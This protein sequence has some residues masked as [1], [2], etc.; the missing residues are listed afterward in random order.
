MLEWL[1]RLK[2]KTIR[3]ISIMLIFTFCTSLLV[4]N[5]TKAMAA[6]STFTESTTA[7]TSLPVTVTINTS[8]INDYYYD[9]NVRY[10]LDGGSTWTSYT[11]PVGIY[12]NCTIKAQYED[13]YSKKS[14][15]WIDLGSFAVS[16]I[17]DPNNGDWHLMSL[18]LKNTSEA[19][20]MVR[21]GDIDNFTYGW[22][23]DFNPFSGNSTNVHGYPW[24][25]PSDSTQATDRIMVNSGYVYGSGQATD[26]YT[27]STSR[28]TNSVRDIKLS[29]DLSGLTVN[30][31]I[32]QMFVD[33]FQAGP[34][35]DNVS[36]HQFHGKYVVKI[37]NLE[38]PELETVINSLNQSGPRGRMISF[39]I[40]DADI[41]LVKSGS[42]SINIDDKVS[43]EGDGYA[44]DFVKLLIN[45]NSLSQTC[46][47][48][49]TIKD[50]TTGKPIQGATISA[51]DVVKAVSA[52]DGTYT[53]NKVPAGTVVATATANGYIT[54]S[55]TIV[56]AVA[57][58]TYTLDFNMQSTTQLAKP[59]ITETPIVTT[60]QNVNVSI[61]YPGSNIAKKLYY[62]SAVQKDPNNPNQGYTIPVVAD[63]Q[64]KTYNGTISIGNEATASTQYF[65]IVQAKTISSLD[66]TTPQVVNCDSNITTYTINNIDKSI[67]NAPILTANTTTPTS[68]SV[69]VTATFPA[70]DIQSNSLK[71]GT[72]MISVDGGLHFTACT[73]NS[74]NQAIVTLDNNATVQA[75]Y[76]NNAGTDSLI[77][78][79]NI[80]NID[81]SV[82]A[83]PII[84]STPNTLADGTT[85]QSISINYPGSPATQ[86]VSF[87]GVTWKNWS[88]IAGQ[89]GLYVMTYNSIIYAKSINAVGTPSTVA[90]LNVNTIVPG[91]PIITEDVTTPTNKDVN[92][93]IQYPAS[94]VQ[95]QYS[96]DGINWVDYNGSILISQNTTVQAKCMDK[97]GTQ[98]AI[99]SLSI[100]NIDKSTPLAPTLSEDVTT[101]TNKDVNVTAQ[102]PTVGVK[103][104]SQMISTDGGKTFAAYTV[105]S[106]NKV[107][108]PV[109]SNGVIE[110]KYT[111]F[112]GTDSIIA[113]L[114]ITNIDKSTP[115]AP[116]L[117]QDITIETSHDV[118]VTIQ[119]PST[120][121]K[122]GSQLVS[123][124]GGQ[125]FQSYNV[126]SN[127][128]VNITL[129]SNA[130]V[131]A[132]YTNL[133]GTESTVGILVVSNIDKS[134]PGTPVITS[135]G[136][137]LADGTTAVKTSVNYPGNPVVQKVSF[138]N[139]ATW[140]D[141]SDVINNDD[142][143]TM[144]YND[145]VL[146]YSI[147][148]LGTNSATAT[149]KISTIKPGTPIMAEDITAPTNENVNVTIQYPASA[150][151]KQ[152]S[153]DGSNWSVYNGPI[154]VLSNLTVEARCIDKAGTV[155]DVASLNITNIDKSVP[156]APILTA[157]ITAPTSKDVT[158]T[159]QFPTTGVKADS[160]LISVNGGQ[161]Y[162]EC[163]V[164]SNGVA[165]ITVGSNCTVEAKYSNL[166]GTESTTAVLN[167]SN[168]DKST[169]VAPTLSQD[170]TGL[171]NKDVTVTAQFPS[172]GVMPGSQMISIDGGQTFIACNVDANNKA[173]VTI[174][175]NTTV[176]AKYTN[177]V[178]VESPTASLAISN[179]DK[180]QPT[181]T[182][183]VIKTNADGSKVIGFIAKSKDSI[184]ATSMT[185]VPFT[186]DTDTGTNNNSSLGTADYV[187]QV[188]TCY[189]NSTVTFSFKDA[190]GNTNSATCDVI[191]GTSNPIGDGG[192]TGGQTTEPPRLER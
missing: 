173:T 187:N 139:G 7:A 123:K 15:A 168:I 118:T 8:V 18:T 56:T 176:E 68:G 70:P 69:I 83:M 121:V 91:K 13:K 76:T 95:R 71:A 93:T 154:Q 21:S 75:K 51:G 35:I 49:G 55:Q 134:V 5:P 145:T 65:W 181:A 2:D 60:N 10:S 37:N 40:P 103:A 177:L 167:I 77:A 26:G 14:T 23:Q 82:P 144:K 136:S 133:A 183:D 110:A 122:T 138:D 73:V 101:L 140:Y 104:N 114:N 129:S 31:A 3:K 127:N 166:V 135:T 105:D 191:V 164:D 189:A 174:S 44:I 74:N 67:P 175:D 180:T 94:A 185:A 92:V 162:K 120:G 171:T 16:N 89:S 124:D 117:T 106:N 66:A 84:T 24:T 17:N 131:E 34:V 188:F 85:A 48:K 170:I 149:L 45:P 39:R 99:A 30:N 178:G 1:D 151:Q 116:T 130:T 9:G 172:K 100:T 19:D 98:S 163:T 87:D 152:Y 33:D 61:D 54:S 112:A 192:Q 137:T 111:N 158:V 102:F 107:T 79:L 155:S 90:T 179:I 81:K 108:I 142:L 29:Y 59:V 80:S 46:T 32:L 78:T 182:I 113:I 47:V 150:V 52:A 147:N 97:A 169:P 115:P 146:A 12:Y 20:M 4:I 159:V 160:Q 43:T 22:D 161:T 53:L 86:L 50:V 27:S 190:A 156:A 41:A 186:N 28:S 109:S 165:I 88:D 148:A 25:Q 141:W 58:N 184:V 38:I 62:V 63:S 64:W 36:P 132:K 119:F 96:I 42:L 126:D 6:T 11:G 125:T 157:D 72:Q 153:L 128:R 57:Q 143:R